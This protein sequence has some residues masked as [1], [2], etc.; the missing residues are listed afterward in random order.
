MVIS[1]SYCKSLHKNL[2]P[3]HA[4]WPL[5]MPIELGSIGELK[6]GVFLFRKHIRD[7]SSAFTVTPESGPA[8]VQYSFTNEKGVHVEMTP[9]A[10]ASVGGAVGVKAGMEIK[11]SQKDLVYFNAAGC[12]NLVVKNAGQLE[13]EIKALYKRRRWNLDWVVVVQ[14]V[15]AQATTAIISSS[16]QSSISLEA[17]SPTVDAINISDGSLKL[18]LKKDNDIAFKMYTQDG[19]LPLMELWQLKEHWVDPPSVFDPQGMDPL[20]GGPSMSTSELSLKF[21]RVVLEE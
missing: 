14:L 11:F 21:E 10:K 6:N 2:K 7:V 3:L 1:E 19:Q 4:V 5:G 8:M 13:D 18:T 15:S 17:S 16:S 12:T 20:G 9:R